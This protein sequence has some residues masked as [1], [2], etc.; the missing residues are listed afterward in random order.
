MKSISEDNATI[1]RAVKFL[2]MAGIAGAALLYLTYT[3]LIK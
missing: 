3:F 2:F 1:T